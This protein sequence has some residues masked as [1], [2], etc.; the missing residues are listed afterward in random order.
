MCE[1]VNMQ[2]QCSSGAYGSIIKGIHME[3][4]L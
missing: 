1:T 2:M 3:K 4:W